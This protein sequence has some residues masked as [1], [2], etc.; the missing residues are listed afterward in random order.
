MVGNDPDPT[1][2]PGAGAFVALTW[3]AAVVGSLAMVGRYGA[4]LPSWDDVGL[5]PVVC[6][7]QPVSLAWLWSPHNEHRLPLNR[8]ALTALMRLTGNDFRSGMVASVS[9]M[10]L[11]TLVLLI[12]LRR[13]RGGWRYADSALPI[14][15][16]GPSQHAV[17]LWCWELQFALS[18]GLSLVLLA[19]LARPRAV[20]GW[21]LEAAVV[22]TVALVLLPLTGANGAAAVP[23]LA[24]G[25]VVSTWQRRK[26]PA[27]VVAG[28]GAV[29]AV[30]L[31]CLVM[32]AALESSRGSP[33]PDFPSILRTA[34]QLLAIGLGPPV[35]GAWP[36]VAIGEVV[37][38][39]VAVWPLLGSIRDRRDRRA[40]PVGLLASLAG[41]LSVVLAVAWGRASAGEAAGLEGRYVTLSAPLL[42][43]I[44]LAL[45]RRAGRGLPRFLIVVLAIV[46]WALLW[47]NAADAIAHGKEARRQA[48]LLNRDVLVD[49]RPTYQVVRRHTPFLGPSQMRVSEA[50]EMLRKANIGPF[51]RL[52]PNP[53]FD[54]VPIDPQSAQLEGAVWEGDRLILTTSNPSASY[55]L[56]SPRFVAGVQLRYDHDGRPPGPAHFRLAWRRPNQ[57]TFPADQVVSEWVLPSGDNRLA[58]I[59][60]DD[61]VAE[62]KVL[63][64]NRPGRFTIRSLKLFVPS[65]DQRGELGAADRRQSQ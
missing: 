60:I 39:A 53:P 11:A 22:G 58:T 31:A 1:E 30:I 20:P 46:S 36:I 15:L 18:A 51:R 65:A 28:I 40:S 54:D 35:S 42:A 37:A 5:L 13:I 3:L 26:K 10:G 45:D 50:M 14:L 52:A 6:G 43:G 38:L 4:N 25:L 47:P 7:E 21:D 56:D 23:A 59:W 17:W 61:N 29:V 9:V 64:D 34:G 55:R 44:Y 27:R 12:A 33:R 24:I 57:M 41:S 19:V 2:E 49:R 48:D 16:V 32:S 62:L 8:L 63:P